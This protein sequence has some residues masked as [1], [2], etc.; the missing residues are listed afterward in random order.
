MAITDDLRRIVTDEYGGRSRIKIDGGPAAVLGG[1][2]GD[3]VLAEIWKAPLSPGGLL[4]GD[5]AMAASPPTLEPG[6]SEAKVR[7]FTVPTDDPAVS[8]EDREALADFAFTLAGA[9]DAR[10][11]TAR[12]PMMHKTETLDV[13]VCVKGRV[14]LLLDDGEATGLKPGDVVIQRSTNHAWV[15]EGDETAVLVA[16]LLNA[17]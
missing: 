8:A 14:T 4:G 10:V 11:D 13:I 15:N 9:K 3:A 5:D 2:F 17:G 6:T 1:E 12:H 7:W 16:V